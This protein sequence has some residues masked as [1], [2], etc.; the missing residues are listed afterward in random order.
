ME[1]VRLGQVPTGRGTP[2]RFVAVESGEGPLLRVDLYQSRDEC[3]V[4]EEVCVW[5]GF[6]VIGWG[7][8][9]YLVEPRTRAVVALYLGSYFRH[10]SKWQWSK[11]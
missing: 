2:D 10:T 8:R 7:N 1:P 9:V 5:S 3:F 6:V 11:F 4:F